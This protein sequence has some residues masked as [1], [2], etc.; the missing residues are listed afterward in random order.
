MYKLLLKIIVSLVIICIGYF[1]L[2]KF[3]F[4]PNFFDFGKKFE[5]KELSIE[6]T[7]LII[8]SVTPL[9]QLFTSTYYSEFPFTETKQTDSY[10]GLTK[11]KHEI[12]IIAKGTCYA[13]TDLSKLSKN[14]IQIAD[15]VTCLVNLPKAEIIDIV[16]NPSDFDIY[17]EEGDWAANE[18]LKVKEKAKNKLK[19]LAEK[20]DVLQKANA[21]SIQMFTDFAKSMGY[22]N[23][24]VKIKN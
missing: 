21:R 16:M 17:I 10:F 23:V 3:D 5:H 11:K 8:E 15:S 7:A 13:G 4:L 19:E 24:T 14:D 18:V 6:P 9:A 2:I 12:I 22:K 20:T 1:A